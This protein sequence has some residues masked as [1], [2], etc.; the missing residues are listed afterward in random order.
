MNASSEIETPVFGGAPSVPLHRPK[1]LVV[2]DQKLN[3]Q[4]LNQVFAADH[5]IFMATSGEQAIALCHSKQPDLILLDVEMPG[6]NGYQV[7]ERLKTDSATRDIPVIFVTSHTDETAEARGLDVGAVDFISK[8]VNPRIVRAR[9]KTHLTLKAQSDVLRQ[10]VYV[11]GLTGVYNRRHFDERLAVEWKRAARNRAA[12]SVVLLD[13]DFFK[14]YNDRYGHQAGDECLRRVA[15]TLK[16]GLKRP[17]DLLAR[18]GGEEFVCLLPDTGLAGAMH[19]ARH[20]GREVSALQIEHVDSTVAPVLTVS[21]GVCSQAEGARGDAAALL[22]TADA[23]LYL[24]KANGR[25]QTCGIELS[26]SPVATAQD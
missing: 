4:V 12:L 18:Y 19:L 17:A 10:W 9:V 5:Q 20:L 3:I 15:A 25:N 8:P 16:E 7:C 13:V 2:D 21:L 14:R 26:A 23:Q 1:L 11:D 24:A 22:R 6:L